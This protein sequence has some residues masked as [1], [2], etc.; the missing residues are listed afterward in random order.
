MESNYSLADIRAATD[1]EE[2]GWGGGW[3]WIVVLFLFM[4]GFGGNGM[5]GN[6]NDGALTRSDLCQDTNFGQLENAVR[7]VQNGLC[8]GFY[9]QNTTMLQGFNGVQRDMCTGFSAVN[10]G[11]AENRFA[12]QQ[13]CCETNRNIDASRFAAQQNTCEITNA[14]HC[15][16]EQTRALINA[17]TMQT[18]RDK[19]AE[20][21][22]EVQS[23]DFQ[24]SQIA[25]TNN[26]VNQ[27]RP[28]PMPA[29]ITCNPWGNTYGYGP[30]GFYGNGG[31]SG[32]GCA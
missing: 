6:R 29:Y 12:A 24:L 30:Y 22:R 31:C 1:H 10:S 18:L 26:I 21:D 5:W 28:C 25:Q 9:A 2:E 11:I 17:N 32:C 16:G 15:E 3:F 20:K 14:I 7:G 19:L 27:V 8:D 4:F 13:C 23:R